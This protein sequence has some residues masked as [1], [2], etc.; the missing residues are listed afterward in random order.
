MSQPA[1]LVCGHLVGPAEP[2]CPAFEAAGVAAHLGCCGCQAWAGWT[3][4][5]QAQPCQHRRC[6]DGHR[7][8][9]LHATAPHIDAHLVAFAS[10]ERSDQERHLRIQHYFGADLE[11]AVRTAQ[12]PDG[13][14]LPLAEVHAWWHIRQRRSLSIGGALADDQGWGWR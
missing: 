2:C 3:R 13:P 1:C 14:A 6:A 5:G 10:Q 8:P 9:A 7:R 11:R 4:P 12:G